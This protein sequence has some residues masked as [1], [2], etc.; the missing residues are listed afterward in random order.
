MRDELGATHHVERIIYT[1][2]L[3]DPISREVRMELGGFKISYKSMNYAYSFAYLDL[4]LPA[5]Y[6]SS[7][8]SGK[9]LDG[10]RWA[11]EF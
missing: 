1:L 8:Q 5:T 11:V 4:T 6:L 10:Y 7:R 2:L 3:V 9:K